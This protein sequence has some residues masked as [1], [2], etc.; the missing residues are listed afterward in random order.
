ME[1]L[2][3]G[4][5]ASWSWDG[6]AVDSIDN[7]TP[8]LLGSP[9]YT[10]P[11]SG[12]TYQ[13]AIRFNGTN[14]SAFLQRAGTNL[15][16]ADDIDFSVE[17]EVMMHGVGATVG[18]IT[19]GDYNYGGTRRSWDLLYNHDTTSFGFETYDGGYVHV[20]SD[21]TVSL[22]TWHHIRAWK[23]GDEIFI[24]VD[25]EEPVSVSGASVADDGLTPMRFGARS[26]TD[27]PQ[28]HANMSLGA[29]RIWVGRALEV[30]WT[31]YLYHDGHGRPDSQLDLI[32][33]M[34]FKTIMTTHLG[35][36]TFRPVAEDEL[37]YPGIHPMSLIDIPEFDHFHS[38]MFEAKKLGCWAVGF[39]HKHWRG[40][41]MGLSDTNAANISATPFYE[42][43][44]IDLTR[45]F[46]RMAKKWG[47][48]VVAYWCVACK[49]FEENYSGPLSY[50]EW[51]LNQHR[52]L[53][54]V[55]NEEGVTIRALI[56][57]GWGDVYWQFNLGVS[58]TEVSYVDV[59]QLWHDLSPDTLIGVNDHVQTGHNPPGDF[60]IDERSNDT[61]TGLASVAYPIFWEWDCL[62]V[63]GPGGRATW[64]G[65]SDATPYTITDAQDNAGCRHR[66]FIARGT[67]VPNMGFPPTS[68]V[69]DTSSVM[70]AEMRRPGNA[71]TITDTFTEASPPVNLQS[72]NSV[73]AWSKVFGVPN[74]VIN[75]SQ[76]VFVN[77]AA[78]YRL[79]GT[80]L[81]FYRVEVDYILRTVINFQTAV[82][83]HSAS[84][85]DNRSYVTKSGST[86]IAAMYV[87]NGGSLSLIS[88]F[89][90]PTNPFVAD[91]KFTLAA[92]KRPGDYLRYVWYEY[93]GPDLVMVPVGHI[94]SNNTV[95]TTGV[96]GVYMDASGSSNVAG[97]QMMQIRIYPIDVIAPT[98]PQVSR[99]TEG[100]I[101]I[102]KPSNVDY[103]KLFRTDGNEL[104]FVD[105]L[106]AADFTDNFLEYTDVDDV[107]PNAFDYVGYS[108]DAAFNV[109]S[110]AA[111][112][113]GG[114]I[115]DAELPVN[116][117]VAF[118]LDDPVLPTYTY[119]KDNFL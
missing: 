67:Y 117:N 75:P 81:P 27:T 62:D 63:Q 23:S 55:A 83:G 91:Y 113:D 65:H 68:L 73:G 22:N 26:Q 69:P 14:Q 16:F 3:T 30:A 90:H 66:T 15:Q 50:N 34:R 48:E 5:E 2:R 70:M 112:N 77:G 19:C 84:N 110:S 25:D 56:A 94:T 101:E 52:E 82:I 87:N 7:L 18:I 99:N 47:F 35:T 111:P 36:P 116:S 64:F 71:A 8:T 9:Q 97:L 24:R 54:Q 72:H 106:E 17:A 98:A 80:E 93:F 28:N 114:D 44:G 76:R 85:N 51:T 11:G 78:D 61:E 57:D 88:S 59:E 92:E 45:L 108:V 37:G 74:Q 21:V 118:D 20:E 53:I 104:V 31:N 105:W 39:T 29:S 10:T 4:L 42:Q 38:L 58:L 33:D 6:N 102:R 103:V 95:T 43:H 1:N 13:R 49:E 86:G 32:D 107:D 96:A 89:E 79:A 41:N 60:G 100:K 119:L 109:S 12:R 40:A 115:V 46:F